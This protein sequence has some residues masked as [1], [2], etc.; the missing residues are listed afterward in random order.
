[1]A[2][3]KR[4][5]QNHF[6]FHLCFYLLMLIMRLAS[7][8][9]GFNGECKAVTHIHRKRNPF[10]T[11]MY[12]LRATTTKKASLSFTTVS[13]IIIHIFSRLHFDWTAE[14]NQTT[15]SQR[16]CVRVSEWMR[17]FFYSILYSFYLI[18]SFSRN[19]A[20]SFR[21]IWVRAQFARTPFEK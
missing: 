17:T 10:C 12:R 15:A 18:P 11:S 1:M 16:V 9:C 20:A 4:K 8:V 13:Y 5:S 21:P 7:F 2:R 19:A 14:L 6:S 3:F